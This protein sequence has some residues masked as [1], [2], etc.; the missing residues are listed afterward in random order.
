MITILISYTIFNIRKVSKNRQ[1]HTNITTVG[2]D[3]KNGETDILANGFFCCHV[4]RHGQ[5]MEKMRWG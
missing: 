2:G 5:K 1:K 4:C 3:E